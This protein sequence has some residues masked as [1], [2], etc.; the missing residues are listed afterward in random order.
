M[1]QPLNS[2]GWTP[3]LSIKG[4]TPHPGVLS[5][6]ALNKYTKHNEQTK[7]STKKA[8]HMF[9]MQL[10]EKQWVLMGEHVARE[11]LLI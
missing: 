2:R 11:P 8:D 10:S 4:A 3:N 1:L 5:T 7:L 9:F 6:L